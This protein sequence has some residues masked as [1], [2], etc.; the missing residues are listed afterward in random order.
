MKGKCDVK[1]LFLQMP[2]TN[3]LETSGNDWKVKNLGIAVHL[4]M[5]GILEK[6]SD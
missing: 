5:Q 1:D 3:K 2:V 6:F 4:L